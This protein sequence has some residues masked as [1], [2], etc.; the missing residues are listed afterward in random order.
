LAQQPLAPSG[1]RR[2]DA[3]ALN[4]VCAGTVYVNARLERR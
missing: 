1:C 3:T 2:Y 4:I